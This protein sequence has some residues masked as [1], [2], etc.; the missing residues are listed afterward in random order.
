MEI[1]R[2][3]NPKKV[4]ASCSVLTA[5]S[6]ILLQVYQVEA[7]WEEVGSNIRAAR[8]AGLVDQPSF[9]FPAVLQGSKAALLGYTP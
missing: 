9:S 2:H 6:L 5:N 1:H 8:T 3:W 7:S 4:R